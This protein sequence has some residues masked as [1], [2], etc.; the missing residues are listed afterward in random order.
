M[1]REHKSVSQPCEVQTGLPQ[2]SVLNVTL[3]VVAINQLISIDQFP[4]T[5]R[6]SADDY[7]IPLRTTTIKIPYKVK[8]IN[9]I[10]CERTARK[11][12]IVS[13]FPH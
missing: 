2:G 11:T 8:L 1:I 9:S 7:S 10:E 12:P 3:F 6:L 4:F 13:G 5:K